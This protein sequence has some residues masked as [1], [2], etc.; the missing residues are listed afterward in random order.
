[1]ATTIENAL[2]L[3]ERSN[4]ITIHVTKNDIQISESAKITEQGKNNEN[5]SFVL[6]DQPLPLPIPA[7]SRPDAP[8]AQTIKIS[9][10]KKG[11]YTLTNNNAQIITASNKQ[12]AAGVHISNSIEFDQ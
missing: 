11:Y 6:N 1:L 8:G 5:F 4:A 3:P 12:W 9:G 7:N 2:G 10:L